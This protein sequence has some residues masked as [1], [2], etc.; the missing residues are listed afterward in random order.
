MAIRAMCK[1][2]TLLTHSVCCHPTT[3]LDDE[4]VLNGFMSRMDEIERDSD[5]AVAKAKRRA[6]EVCTNT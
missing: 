3:R 6:E 4:E 2:F 1:Y 5:E